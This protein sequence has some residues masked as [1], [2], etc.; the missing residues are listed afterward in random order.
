VK[1]R[2]G[3]PALYYADGLDFTGEEFDVE[4]YGALRDAWSQWRRR[5]ESEVR[6]TT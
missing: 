1:P 2:L 3:I 5:R 4:D 6:R